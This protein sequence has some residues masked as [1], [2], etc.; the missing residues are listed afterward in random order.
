MLTNKKNI[1][2]L[3]IE[4][5]YEIMKGLAITKEITTTA[6]AYLSTFER[7]D[8]FKDMLALDMLLSTC[9]NL[10]QDTFYESAFVIH[11][12][13]CLSVI[14]DII[15][16]YVNAEQVLRYDGETIEFI[17][18]GHSKILAIFDKV[19]GIREKIEEE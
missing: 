12:E 4:S 8:S 1:K 11:I 10:L 7:M 18:E 6:A 14:S 9:Q 13:T 3:N 17:N 19:I 15:A 16:K 2:A 5:M